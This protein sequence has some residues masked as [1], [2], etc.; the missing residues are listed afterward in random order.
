MGKIKTETT[1][2]NEIS[3][4]FPVNLSTKIRYKTGVRIPPMYSNFDHMIFSP[5]DGDAVS[6]IRQTDPIP[7]ASISIAS[8]LAPLTNRRCHA[9]KTTM[10]E[11]S[12]VTSAKTEYMV[13]TKFMV[14]SFALMCK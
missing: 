5:T 6:K 3:L 11:I 10:K 4:S 7:A 8:S 2:L 1:F 14:E 9:K 12:A 13:K